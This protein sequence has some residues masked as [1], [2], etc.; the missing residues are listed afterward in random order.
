M[1]TREFFR[2]RREER[3]VVKGL[4]ILEEQKKEYFGV[5]DSNTT[6]SEIADELKGLQNE[7]DEDEE[8]SDDESDESEDDDDDDQQDDDPRP[9][10]SGKSP[11][12]P[13]GGGDGD[14]DSGGNDRGYGKA[15]DEDIDRLSNLF[16]K[17]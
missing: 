14:G 12:K 2:R 17:S 10:G 3:Y 1:F 11:R 5:E 16:N 9:R 13:P 4:E 6:D 7:G 15:D 8:E